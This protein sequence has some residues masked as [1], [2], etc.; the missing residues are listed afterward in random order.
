MSI[1]NVDPSKFRDFDPYDYI[2]HTAREIEIHRKAG[3][4][5]IADY[6][7]E[8]LRFFIEATQLS[9]SN[10]SRKQMAEL[11]VQISGLKTAICDQLQSGIA[12]AQKA[13]RDA[14]KSAWVNLTIAIISLLIN[15]LLV[16]MQW[17]QSTP[18]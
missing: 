2:L 10:E 12:E 18:K 5:H 13:V 7:A 4:L 3:R 17:Q 1:E 6:Q 8:N 9:S 15:G 14:N 16:F 11:G